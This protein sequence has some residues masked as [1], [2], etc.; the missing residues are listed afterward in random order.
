MLQLRN[1]TNGG[2]GIP[3]K[4]I[5]PCAGEAPKPLFLE[6]GEPPVTFESRCVGLCFLH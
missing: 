4:E 3:V 5:A 1:R 2:A 6:L